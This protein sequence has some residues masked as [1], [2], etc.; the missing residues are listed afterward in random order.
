MVR[1]LER[2][3]VGTRPVFAGNIL[4]QPAYKNIESR[5]VGDL[6]NSNEIMNRAFWIGV[7]PALTPEMLQYMLEV[8]EASVAL[9][10]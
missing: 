6:K 8:L 9:Q 5:V 10:L 7:H 1:E 4:R 2:R 3:K